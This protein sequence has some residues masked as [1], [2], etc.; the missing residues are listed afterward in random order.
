[1]ADLPRFTAT[2][3]ISPAPLSVNNAGLESLHS[4]AGSV[5]S[6]ALAENRKLRKEHL[7]AIQQ[8]SG[9]DI[10]SKTEAV[11]T[12]AELTFTDPQKQKDFFNTSMANYGSTYIKTLPKEARQYAQRV[13]SNS[14]ISGQ[15]GFDHRIVEQQ[16]ISHSIA[17]QNSQD[18]D[19][20]L[21]STH[22]KDNND[23]GAQQDLQRITN[24]GNLAALSRITGPSQASA[25]TKKAQRT[26]QGDKFLH[27]VDV[28]YNQDIGNIK[29][30]K[31][32]PTNNANNYINS[33]IKKGIPGYTNEE[34]V[35]LANKAHSLMKIQ[36]SSLNVDTKMVE[37]NYNIALSDAIH[38]GTF[39]QN[40]VNDYLST[41]LG[42]E[43]FVKSQIDRNLATHSY[44]QKI[45]VEPMTL[46]ND[47]MKSLKKDL[48]SLQFAQIQKGVND[49]NKDMLKDSYTHFQSDPVV[50]HAQAREAE[51]NEGIEEDGLITE[52]NNFQR[53]TPLQANL[54]LQKHA[55]I[56][57][58]KLRVMSKSEANEF[59]QDIVMLPEEQ[60][61]KMMDEFLGR[62][63]T[64]EEQRIGSKNLSDAGLNQNLLMIMTAITNPLTKGHKQTLINWL[65]SDQ[66]DVNDIATKVGGN[67]FVSNINNE[68]ASNLSDFNNSLD[69]Y[70]GDTAS[71]KDHVFNQ[72]SNYA[73]YLVVN[74]GYGTSKA[75]EEAANTLVNK[76]LN[77]PTIG[78]KVIQVKK[79]VDISDLQNAYII[80]LREALNSKL[81][82]PKSYSIHYPALSEDELMSQYKSDRINNAYMLSDSAQSKGTLVDSMGFKITKQGDT[83][84]SFIINYDDLEN[85][86][87]EQY[88]DIVQ[89]RKKRFVFKSLAKAIES[90]K[91]IEG[92]GGES[93][94]R[95]VSDNISKFLSQGADANKQLE[96]LRI[97]SKEK[98][99]GEEFSRELE[100]IRN[101]QDIQGRDPRPG[102]IAR[103][104]VT[105]ETK[106]VKP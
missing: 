54:N 28:L 7:Q 103:K 74:K 10:A 77:Y 82:I 72:V 67:N 99:K 57:D 96:L 105:E 49:S 8:Q 62:F 32:S 73:K 48:D 95:T 60:K 68:V 86:N 84:S 3:P 65:D 87:S 76:N 5:E 94:L 37:Q 35:T 81:F 46:Q 18:T 24:R 29:D 47:E 98:G 51:V 64:T 9:T 70:A 69:N 44:V 71:D 75:A 66:K 93:K 100:R 25:F 22:V 104:E 6:V 58:E 1:M 14:M 40:S 80:K 41:H 12:Q 27:N 36:Q 39:N 21:I 16:R 26:Y 4:L 101:L 17:Y 61:I 83:D 33:M 55:D 63:K 43:D 15:T 11:K 38:K 97:E 45:S 42:E 85:V 92:L 30:P 89:Q 78:G 53:T 56:P 90:D 13:F 88:K 79:G 52:P 106:E 50:E 19:L 20:G 34:V 59:V 2:T 102:I 23:L 31:K 91:R